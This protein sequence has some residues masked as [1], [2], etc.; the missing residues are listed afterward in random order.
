MSLSLT[1]L[2]RGVS[3]CV[4]QYRFCSSVPKLSIDRSHGD[5]DVIGEKMDFVSPLEPKT[6]VSTHDASADR[7]LE[8]PQEGEVMNARSVPRDWTTQRR[9]LQL[10][11]T[12][13]PER[14][15]QLVAAMLG[16]PNSGKSTLANCLVGR[17]ICRYWV[18]SKCTFL[19]AKLLKWFGCALW[20]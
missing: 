10:E 19:S 20:N 17:K 9:L 7:I 11:A 15:R 16:A 8:E 1:R 2:V 18:I 13:Q 14:P 6:V 5:A 12:R 3:Y 4:N